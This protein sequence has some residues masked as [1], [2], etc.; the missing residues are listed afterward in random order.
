MCSLFVIPFLRMSYLNGK[1]RIE[2][3]RVLNTLPTP[4]F[5]KLLISIH[6]PQDFSPHESV[7]LLKWVE[8][9]DGCGLDK[10]LTA[11]GKA[12]LVST[13]LKAVRSSLVSPVRARPRHASQSLRES[14]FLSYR[15]SDSFLETSQIY[16][17]LEA[18]LGEGSILK[19]IDSLPPGHVVTDHLNQALSQCRVMLV[20]IGRT[21][22][23]LTGENGTRH[24]DNPNDVVRCEI[25][26]ALRNKKILLVPVLVQGASM[27][28]DS[29]LPESLRLLSRHN[30][31]KI[32]HDS[33]FYTDINRLAVCIREYL[34]KTL[35][36]VALPAGQKSSQYSFPTQ[37]IYVDRPLKKERRSKL[38]KIP[39]SLQYPL[40]FKKEHTDISRRKIKKVQQLPKHYQQELGNLVFLEMSYIPGGRFWMG[41]PEEDTQRTKGEHPQ[42]KVKVPA[43]YMS[44]Y[45]ITQQQ[46]YA[47]SLFDD[48]RRELKPYPS[49]FEGDNLPVENVSWYDAVEFCQ[50]LSI[51]TGNEYRL[52]SEAEWEY[53]CRAGTTTPFHFGETIA[54]DH[55][56]YNGTYVY[57][58]GRKGVYRKKTTPVDLFLPN[59]FGIYDMHGNVWEWCQDYWHSDYIHA[60][61]DSS[62]W[63]QGGD[64]KYRVLRGG[65]WYGLP[66]FCRT[67]FRYFN[68]PEYRNDIVGIRVVCSS[69]RTLT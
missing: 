35:A 17:H 24:L 40:S 41:S 60:P 15:H 69:L 51:Y 18:E 65:S 42:H 5:H 31:T 55:A 38:S 53:A 30:A 37:K 27:P 4:V 36:R 2:L 57:D 33:Q 67:A 28:R 54:T 46:W 63:T 64:P 49:R 7:N 66:E 59:S 20:I 8:S 12:T 10:F 1:E 58:Q 34:E 56:N 25:E 50:R 43:F 6:A 39:E 16:E 48:V 22:L 32:G 21:W 3:L 9:R 19:D 26:S 11:L 61:K 68:Q 45:P 29:Q 44:K 23:T 47:V 14:I 13:D 52:P 62:P